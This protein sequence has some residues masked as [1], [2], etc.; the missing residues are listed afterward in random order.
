MFI[1]F[2]DTTDAYM[3]F[4]ERLMKNRIH[5]YCVIALLCTVIL[6]VL[7]WVYR[8]Y[9]ESQ[10]IDDILNENIV[11]LFNYE[12]DFRSENNRINGYVRPSRPSNFSTISSAFFTGRPGRLRDIIYAQID[13]VRDDNALEK[14]PPGIFPNIQHLFI[15]GDVFNEK[16]LQQ[17][18][19]HRNLLSLDLTF[20][21][22]D[23]D[24]VEEKIRMYLPNCSVRFLD[25]QNRLVCRDD[26]LFVHDSW[27]GHFTFMSLP[28]Q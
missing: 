14:I 7:W 12:Y 13:L 18:V 25:Y 3:V 2:C 8:A 23:V 10:L 27:Q 16:I 11:V 4:E 5:R 19:S 26:E 17:I 1:G 24:C 22:I 6:A 28:F 21:V 15:A 9:S 20:R